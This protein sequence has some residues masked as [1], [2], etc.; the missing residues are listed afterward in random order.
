MPR[1]VSIGMAAQKTERRTRSMATERDYP[2]AVAGGVVQ[3]TSRDALN[4]YV[5]AQQRIRP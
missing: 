5:S 1:K 3:G 4:G 2:A